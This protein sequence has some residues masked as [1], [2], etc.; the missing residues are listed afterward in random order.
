MFAKGMYAEV[1]GEQAEV[2]DSGARRGDFG[3]QAEVRDSG[4]RRGD[5]GEQA[6]VRDSGNERA[7]VRVEVGSLHG[8]T[9]MY[10][11]D[12][13]GDSDTASAR[14]NRYFLSDTTHCIHL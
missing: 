1:L 10:S 5:F 11:S 7:A 2:R 6:E 8:D 9:G 14:K 12:D 13:A 4:A 3:E